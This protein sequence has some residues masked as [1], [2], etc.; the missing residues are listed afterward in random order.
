M[1]KVGFR[2]GTPRVLMGRPDMGHTLSPRDKRHRK[3][4]NMNDALYC[5]NIE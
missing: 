1:R 5:H 4:L 2:V 3:L